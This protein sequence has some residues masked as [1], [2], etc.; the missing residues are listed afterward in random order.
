MEKKVCLIQTDFRQYRPTISI[1]TKPLA[2]VKPLPHRLEAEMREKE[3]LQKA[4][5]KT[6]QLV[7]RVQ[8]LEE[9]N[10]GL[11]KERNEVFIRLQAVTQ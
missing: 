4:I 5:E 10:A 3:E 1:Q 2:H 11:L 6:G 8:E 9:K 7:S